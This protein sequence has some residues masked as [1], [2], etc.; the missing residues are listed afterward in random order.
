M[1]T[2]WYI[3]IKGNEG[4]SPIHGKI[5]GGTKK[6]AIAKMKAMAEEE[7]K[8]LQAREPRSDI[9]LFVYNIRAKVY[10]INVF[11]GYGHKREVVTEYQVKYEKVPC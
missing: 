8:E 11:G 5:Y 1:K 9:R 6:E 4:F 10:R 2:L 3:H 7:K